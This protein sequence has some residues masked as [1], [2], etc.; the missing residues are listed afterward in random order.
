MV[1]E[2]GGIC[3]DGMRPNSPRLYPQA[4]WEEYRKDPTK[5]VEKTLERVGG[6]HRDFVNCIRN[7]GKTCS[8]FS[9][10]GPLTEAI[11]LGTLAIRTG[12]NL[13]WDEKN[14]KIKGNKEA[15]A[16]IEVEARKGWGAS[17]LA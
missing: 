15:S 8:D 16:L 6:I 13:Q 7:G 10:S 11:L 3:H 12:K 9:Y 17:D 14:L 2:K 1:G 5:R 4:K